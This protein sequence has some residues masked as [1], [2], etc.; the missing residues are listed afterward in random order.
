ME[1]QLYFP[2]DSSSFYERFWSNNIF[3]P[4]QRVG[5]PNLE[6]LASFKDNLILIFLVP[7]NYTSFLKLQLSKGPKSLIHFF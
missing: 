1:V 6:L 4:L 7:I 3:N 2:I 5:F